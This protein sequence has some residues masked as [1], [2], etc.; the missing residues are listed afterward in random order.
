MSLSVSLNMA[1]SRAKP[2]GKPFPGKRDH[3]CRSSRLRSLGHAK[4]SWPASV[5]LCGIAF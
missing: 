1:P 3:V 4:K 5:K 2:P